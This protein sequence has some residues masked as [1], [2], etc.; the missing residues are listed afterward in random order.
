MFR[1]AIERLASSGCR[2]HAVSRYYRTSAVGSHA[3]EDF[4]N[5]AV[6]IDTDLSAEALL[7][8][9]Q[10]IETEL[11]RVRSIRWGPRTID[12]DLLLY[13][14]AVIETPR[15]TVPHPCC[16]YRRFVL[17]PLFEIAAEVIHPGKAVTIAEL[18]ARLLVRPLPVGLAGGT[19]E[20]RIELAGRSAAEFPEARIFDWD[21]AGAVEQVT[22]ALLFWL[23][24]P[25]AQQATLSA[26]SIDA[27]FLALPRL[28][29]LD[30]PTTVRSSGE[31]IHDAVQSALGQ[32]VPVPVE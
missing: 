6:A 26:A 4:L 2:I 14:G 25:S 21:I 20:E 1:Q 7:E 3:G 23:G 30:V 5:A 32:P 31:F 24:S 17:D 27:G 15:L 13:G 19:H 22:P 10:S 8:L 28:P 12:L 16:W 9:L 11:G 18:H 29:R